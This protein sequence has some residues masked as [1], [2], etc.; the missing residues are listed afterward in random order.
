MRLALTVAGPMI[1]AKYSK[2]PAQVILRRHLEHRIDALGT[3]VR[4]GP[5]P[6][7]LTLEN[8]GFPLAG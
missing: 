6:D 7:S 4:G 3:G 1:A 8:Y 2:T 5:D